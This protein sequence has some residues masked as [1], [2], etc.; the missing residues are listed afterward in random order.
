[1][2]TQSSK[3]SLKQSSGFAIALV[4]ALGLFMAVL[5]T[6]IVNVGLVPMAKAFNTELNVIQWVLTGYLLAQAAVIPVA[7]YL[8]NIFGIRRTFALSLTIFTIGSL[9]C[10]LAPDQGWLI[11]FRVLQGIGAG[12]VKA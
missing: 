1:M 6:T 5:D 3:T 4:A 9:L 10:A 12:A 8:S 7:G 2:A 11:A